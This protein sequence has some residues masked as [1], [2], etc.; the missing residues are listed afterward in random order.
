MYSTYKLIVANGKAQEV[1]NLLA[2]DGYEYVGTTSTYIIMGL[3]K[4]DA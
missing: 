2:D 4:T 3:P 1:I